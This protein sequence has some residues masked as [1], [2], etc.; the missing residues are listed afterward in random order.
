MK[1]GI[2]LDDTLD[3]TDGIQQYVLCLGEWLG[4]RGHK[5]CFLVGETY[6]KD[7]PDLHSLSRNIKVTFNGNRLSMPL[8]VSKRTL[9]SL[10]QELQLDILHV[11]TPYSPFLGGRLIQLAPAQTAVIGTFHILPY[12]FM[13]RLGSGIL[14]KINTATAKRFDAMMA[15]STPSQVFAGRHYGFTSVVMANPF[16]HDSF[17]Q[18]RRGKPATRNIKR[19]VFLGRLVERKGAYELLKA[20]QYLLEHKL[21]RVAFEVVIAGKGSQHHKLVNFTQEA[22]LTDVVT[23]SG[24]VK[25][26]DKAS[27]LASA[28][29]A[30]FPSTAGESFGISLLEAMAAC[31][32]VVLAGDNPGYASVVADPR[33]L[34]NPTETTEFAKVL[35]RWLSDDII[36][37]QIA[38]LQQAYVKQ[39]DI[40]VIG[41]RIEEIYTHALQKRRAS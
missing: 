20:I 35:A 6:R 12:G 34:F 27:L 9:K 4:A 39:F 29:I 28:D 24:F 11:Q 36:R 22:G 13:A 30:V 41:P 7:L 33:Q 5:V 31:R 19:I 25:E 23:F 32:G 18:A 26:P 14:G 2:V 8:P 1:I 16:R 15:T 40:D 17:S 10:L 38:K 37:D 3:T 21:T